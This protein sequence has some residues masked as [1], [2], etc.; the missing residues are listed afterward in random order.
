MIV[1]WAHGFKSIKWLQQLFATNDYRVNDTYALSNNDPESFLKTAAYLDKG[2]TEFDANEPVVIT[3]Q[4]IN[5]YSGL[6]SVEFWMRELLPGAKRLDDDSPELKNAVWKKC[7][8]AP[9]LPH[10]CSSSPPSSCIPDSNTLVC[11][12]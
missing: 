9:W 1:P 7:E 5:G 12:L 2:A 10:R 4:A 11:H 6:Q 3:G 8:L